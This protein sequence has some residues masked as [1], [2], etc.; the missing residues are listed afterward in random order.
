MYQVGE[1]VVY[2]VQ[3]VCRVLGTECQRINRK[4]TEYLVLEPITRGESKF[5]LPTENSAA[6]AKLQPV[7]SRQE[8]EELLNSEEIHKDCW[9]QEENQRKQH[10]RQLVASCD[11]ISLVQMLAAV[12]RHKEEQAASGKKFHLCDDNFLRDAEKLICSEICLVMEMEPDQAR[13]YLRSQLQ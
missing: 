2:G 13:Q 3:G 8:L 10:Y 9:I 6:L 4:R 11:R 1:Y 7:L 12:Y 5:Y